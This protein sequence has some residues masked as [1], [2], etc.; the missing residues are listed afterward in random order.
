MSWTIE[1]GNGRTYSQNGF[2][3][4]ET[5]FETLDDLPE[6]ISVSGVVII[7]NKEKLRYYNGLTLYAKLVEWHYFSKERPLDYKKLISGL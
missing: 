1:D 5:V 6:Q 4:E 3:K 2:G 7:L